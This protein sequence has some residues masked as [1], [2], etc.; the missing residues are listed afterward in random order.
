MRCLLRRPGSRV[1]SAVTARPDA[2]SASPE[3]AHRFGVL[4]AGGGALVVV[5]GLA[6]GRLA[7]RCAAGAWGGLCFGLFGL[8]AALRPGHRNNAG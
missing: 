4:C 2:L 3:A 6:S 5:G 8:G 1:V 7:L